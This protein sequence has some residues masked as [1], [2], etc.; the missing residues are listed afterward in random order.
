M[1]GLYD[2]Y[3]ATNA[4][5]K[6]VGD[7]SVYNANVDLPP[8]N[9][10]WK[11]T[12]ELLPYGGTIDTNNI[13]T[14]NKWDSSFNADSV[15]GLFDS[16]SAKGFADTVGGIGGLYQMYQGNKMLGLYGQQ[17]ADA[18]ENSKLMRSE[19]ARKNTTRDKWNSAFSS[20]HAGV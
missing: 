11:N 10:N 3:N 20:A 15:G 13:A 12:Q 14:G 6:Y 17:V 19:V 4:A 18:K 9:M 8:L 5:N 1:I 2:N 7:K 16:F